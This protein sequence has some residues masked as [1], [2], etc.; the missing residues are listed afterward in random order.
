MPEIKSNKENIILNRLFYEPYFSTKKNS[1][2]EK[3]KRLLERLRSKT[4]I[5]SYKRYLGTPL[6]YAGGKTLA[7]GH[8]INLLPTNIKRVVS[9]FFVSLSNIVVLPTPGPPVSMYFSI[10]IHIYL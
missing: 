10:K 1:L 8:I 7:V 5:D 4:K 2:A 6:R 9:P 3:K